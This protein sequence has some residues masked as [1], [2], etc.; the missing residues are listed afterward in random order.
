MLAKFLNAARASSVSTLD[1]AFDVGALGV[2]AGREV[3]VAA[4]LAVEPSL[5]PSCLASVDTA[6]PGPARAVPFS[7]GFAVGIISL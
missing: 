3:F 6:L 1:V 7:A 4:A 2:S 5:A